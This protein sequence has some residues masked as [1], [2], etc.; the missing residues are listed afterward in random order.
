MAGLALTALAAAG[1]M[2]S[3]SP[4]DEWI[5]QEVAKSVA[6]SSR[7]AVREAAPDAP[8]P[9]P[10]VPPAGPAEVRLTLLEALRLALAGS[11][12]VQI[13]GLQPRIAEQDII[14][15]EAV[16]DPAA[17]ATS[18]VGRVDRPIQSQLDVGAAQRGLLVQDTWSWQAGL[19]TKVPTGG[20]L[21]VYEASDYLS[22]NSRLILPNPQDV[23]RLT[24][25]L[26]HPLLRGAGYDYN[27]AAIR[28]ANLN[29]SVAF[30]DFRKG[31]QDAVAAV[32]NA[33][34]QLA[35]DLE[36]VRVSRASR[37]LATEV[38]RREKSRREQGVSSDLDVSRAEAAV[39][40][41]EAD[42]IRAESQSRDSMDRLKLLMNSRDLDLAD[43]TRLLPVEAPRFFIVAVDRSAAIAAALG[44]R[45]DLE[46]ARAAVAVNRIRL[47]VADRDRLP[48]LD[49][50]LR[51]ILGGLDADLGG[52]IENQ[53]FGDRIS[54]NAGLELE[55]PLGN[56]SADATRRKRLLEYDQSILELD[57][58]A[59]QVMQEVNAS[60]RAVLLAR[61]EVEA[62]LQAKTAAAR[63]VQGEQRRFELGLTTN[64]ELL[65]AQ[66][67]L[68][69]AERDHLKALLNFNLGLVSLARAQGVL[70]DA[71]GIEIVEPPST[72]DHP[73]PLGLRLAPPKGEA[74][75]PE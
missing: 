63:T 41:R 40:L 46:R 5:A 42:G 25:E 53:N 8:G 15:A 75:K 71:Q 51:Y 7:P 60:A 26:A 6:S 35:F 34:W 12:D 45:P 68:A 29:S 32:V 72:P 69:T 64:E 59:T 55:V 73:R 70:L 22:T 44:R 14:V 43:E 13:A 38:L 58:L 10:P 1:C 52:A 23:T 17:F 2:R 48:K 18:T 30:Q 37:D 9:R 31:V 3:G 36:S 54:W 27:T 19:R 67:T 61:E 56:R 49:A 33:Y 21:S 4:T 24:V 16:F 39:A 28:V 47:D 66:E 50:T 74:G 57:R 62:T 11:H 65:R 20:A